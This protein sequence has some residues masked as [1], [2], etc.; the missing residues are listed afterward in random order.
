VPEFVRLAETFVWL[1]EQRHLADYDR[2]RTF[3]K[4]EARD[5]LSRTEAAF[6]DWEQI[7]TTPAAQVFLVLLLLG[8]RWNHG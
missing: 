6:R 4:S 2:V 3:D 5:A 7:R 1:Q 8:D